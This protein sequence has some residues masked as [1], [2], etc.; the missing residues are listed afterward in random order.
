[1]W[2]LCA[3]AEGPE[4]DTTLLEPTSQGRLGACEQRDEGGKSIRVTGAGYTKMSLAAVSGCVIVSLGV[5]FFLFISPRPP[6]RAL[7][8]SLLIIYPSCFLAGHVKSTRYLF[9]GKKESVLS[10]IHI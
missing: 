3:S 5:F 4:V 10:L 1:M 7:S 8:L 2:G 6:L 9:H